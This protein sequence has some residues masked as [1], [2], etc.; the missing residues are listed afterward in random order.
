MQFRSFIAI[1]VLL[2]AAAETFGLVLGKS[3]GHPPEASPDAPAPP[4]PAREITLAAVGDVMLARMVGVRIARYGAEYP[5]E[6]TKEILRS[7]DITFANLESPIAKNARLQPKALAFKAKPSAVDG[8]VRAGFDVVSLANNHALDAGRSGLR[9]TMGFLR[10]AGIAAVGVG[11]DASA[12][13]EPVI[14]E[15]GGMRVA[16]LAYC[17]LF[18]R[19]YYRDDALT[20]ARADAET[21]SEDIASAK[22]QA[23][24]VIV[25]FH[26]G[27]EYRFRSSERQRKLAHL[28]I[29][30][31]ADLVLGHHPHVLQETEWYHGGFIAY[32]LG[33]FVFDPR[34]RDT[35]ESAILM[36]T[37]SPSGARQV[38]AIPVIF[39]ASQP[40]PA[41]ARA[42]ERVLARL[43]MPQVAVTAP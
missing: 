43:G 1:L 2:L 9:E 17:D 33:N 19:R 32:I 12:A 23:D 6:E 21:L 30:S 22:R 16:F 34:H 7:T 37:L 3:L 39:P 26:W 25:S 41:D 5:F 18:P 38:K 31:G 13:R 29:D 35:N 36:V 20:F 10:D 14:M 24:V 8:L 15:A 4:A 11:E 42:A 27:H 28:A 40:M